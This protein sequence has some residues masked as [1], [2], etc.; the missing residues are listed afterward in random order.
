MFFFKFFFPAL[1]LLILAAGCAEMPLE[2][3]SLVTAPPRVEPAVVEARAAA[4]KELLA[5]CPVRGVLIEPEHL[6]AGYIAEPGKLV[7]NAGAFGFN[8]LFLVLPDTAMLSADWFPRL[9]AAAHERGMALELLLFQ[10]DYVYHYRGN[11]IIR[12]FLSGGP[13]L[14]DAARKILAYNRSHRPEQRIDA[15]TVAIEPDSFTLANQNRPKDLLFAWSDRTFGPGLDNDRIMAYTVDRVAEAARLFAGKVGFTVGTGDFYQELIESGK[16]TR[17]GIGEL[18]EVAP[19]V[20]VRN[21]GNKPSEAVEVV[22][23]ELA[24][25]GTPGSVLIGVNVAEHTAVESGALRRRDWNDLVRA[26]AHAMDQWRLAPAF[27]GVV[28]GPF[29]LIETLQKEE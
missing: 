2:S 17:G 13:T 25:A 18:L 12:I 23:N 10:S 7:R 21:T 27:G 29:H 20:L 11:R 14:P 8:R 3:S 15:V 22:Q 28:L 26:L 6:T 16:L 9:A 4:L 19:R 1:L 5:E 24:V